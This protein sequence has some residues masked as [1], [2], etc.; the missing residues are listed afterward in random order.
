MTN[1]EI[2]SVMKGLDDLNKLNVPLN[3]KVSYNLA[4]IKSVLRPLAGLIQEKQMEL[5]RKY[6]ERSDNNTIKV[7]VEKMPFLEADLKELLD[8]ENE[9]NITKVK[10][11]D[12]GDI[13]ILFDIIEELIPVI[14]E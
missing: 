6:G 12:F 3:I 14:E 13:E 1:E 8:I 7:P 11:H 5:Y 9:V 4:K 2:L 10:I